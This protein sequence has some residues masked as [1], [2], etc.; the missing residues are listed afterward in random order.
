VDELVHEVLDC[1]DAYYDAHRGLLR[2]YGFVALEMPLALRPKYRVVMILQT[3]DGFVTRHLE[4]TNPRNT[5]FLEVKNE[6]YQINPPFYGTT[7]ATYVSGL[8]YRPD[9]PFFETQFFE[10]DPLGPGNAERLDAVTKVRVAQWST[11]EAEALAI[12][13]VSPFINIPQEPE[14]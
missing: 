1:Y 3:D 11:E 6:V 2:Q 12:E 13:H 9:Q 7:L 8:T 5:Y 10:E 14:G 4:T